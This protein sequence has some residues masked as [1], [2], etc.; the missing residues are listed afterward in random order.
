[1]NKEIVMNAIVSA[2]NLISNELDSIEF[3][4][5]RNEYEITLNELNNALEEIK[6]M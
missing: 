1:M 4:D 5:L 3:D 2:I 6:R